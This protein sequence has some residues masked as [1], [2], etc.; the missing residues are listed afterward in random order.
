[1][2]NSVKWLQK[3]S[4]FAGIIVLWSSVGVGMLRTGLGLIDQ[5]PISYL[6]TDPASAGLFTYGLLISA[7]LFIVFGH[8]VNKVFKVKNK[9][10]LYLIIGQLGQITA[11]LFKFEGH[12]YSHL[13]HTI[14]AF[15]LA[16]SLPLL[17]RRFYQSQTKSI[18]FNLYKNL[19][20]F[21]LLTFVVGIGLFVFTKGI[22]PLGEILPTI[23][24]HTWIVALTFSKIKS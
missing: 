21:E 3:Y 15:V 10:F 2:F 13:T 4:G 9:F 20:R 24:F 11:A 8:Y 23:G 14:A 1:M 22:A 19:F 6:G 17:T 5:R 16:F 12:G 18:Y 7:V